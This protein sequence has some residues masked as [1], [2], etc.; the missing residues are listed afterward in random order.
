MANDCCSKKNSSWR[1]LLII[2]YFIINIRVEAGFAT[3]FE[4]MVDGLVSGVVLMLLVYAGA[5]LL[6]LIEVADNNELCRGGKAY[7]DDGKE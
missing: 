2:V 6:K 5:R 3:T 7:C 1:Y 4:R